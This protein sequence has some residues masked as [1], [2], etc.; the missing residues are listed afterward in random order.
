MAGSFELGGPIAILGATGQLGSD[1]VRVAEERGLPFEALGHDRIEVTEPSPV[2][3]VI[4]DI[5][6]A[7]VVNSAAFHGVDGCETDP[8][9]AY[10]VNAVGAG[11]VARAAA[12]LDAR[13]IYVSTD[14]V[15]DG[16]K[17]AP[18]NGQTT[19]EQAYTHDDRPEPVNV[20]GSSKLAGEH[21][22]LQ[23]G[24]DN[25][26]A[27]VSSL[28]GVEGARGKGGGNFV[29]MMLGFA[30][31]GRDLAGVTDQWMTPTYTVDAAQAL[32]DLARTPEATGRVHVTSPEA[33]TWYDLA[34]HALEVAGYDVEIDEV[35]R[36]A[37]AGEAEKPQN[38]ALNTDCLS[39]FLG[40]RLPGW[41]KMVE[42]YIEE[43]SKR[44]PS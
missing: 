15:F 29:D 30:D 25:L 24:E 20:Y 1:L 37:F 12:D 11:H 39:S 17:P 23:A 10:E 44:T 40:R 34:E 14:Y 35:G 28:F 31:E 21:L 41:R 38:S 32:L 13:T 9:K 2:R 6:P 33:C 8:S 16:T 19:P 36:E 42:S 18:E 3:K 7:V 4:A 22:T 43:K 5:D 26:V 27:R